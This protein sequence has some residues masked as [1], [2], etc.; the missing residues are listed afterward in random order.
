MR[1]ETSLGRINNGA[2][3]Q[4]SQEVIMKNWSFLALLLVSLP[5]WA[6]DADN[7]SACVK[8][9]KEFSGMTLDPFAAAYE[10]NIV[11]PS[12]AKWENVLCEVKFGEVYNLRIQNQYVIYKGYAG[13]DAY[14]LNKSLETKTDEAIARMDTHIALLKQRLDQV[15][16]SL[17]KPNPDQKWLNRY[18]EEGIDKSFGA[19]QRSCDSDEVK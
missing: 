2:V 6:G 12:T 9:A 10:S 19:S 14:E 17:R 15:D 5:V 18:I 11:S 7:I 16:V 3:L 1:L 4:I 13:K 8:K